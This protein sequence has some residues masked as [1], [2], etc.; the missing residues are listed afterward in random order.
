MSENTVNPIA[1]Q[2]KITNPLLSV[3]F[4]PKVT[5]RHIVDHTPEKHVQ[6]LAVISGIFRFIDQS[7]QKSLGDTVSMLGILGLAVLIGIPAGLISL[8]LTGALFRWTGSWL[9]GNAT[10]RDVRAVYAWSSVVDIVGLIIFLPLILVFGRGWFQSSP[11]WADSS[12][13]LLIVMLLIPLGLILL[14]WRAVIFLSGLAEVHNFSIWKSL[15]ATVLGF[16]I[17]LIPILCI[18]IPIALTR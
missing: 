13:G 1:Q 15:V 9:G 6:L 18:L 4:H 14:I 16:M 12:A 11:S 7:S 3:W 17:L 10:D 5:I 2:E 8:Y